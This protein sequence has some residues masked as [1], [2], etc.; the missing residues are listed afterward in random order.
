M[1]AFCIIEVTQHSMNPFMYEQNIHVFFFFFYSFIKF[2]LA[3]NKIYTFGLKTE[4]E[5]KCMHYVDLK[6]STLQ[7]TF[8]SQLDF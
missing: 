4:S 7:Y 8:S 2:S 5:K 1:K 6:A 3:Y